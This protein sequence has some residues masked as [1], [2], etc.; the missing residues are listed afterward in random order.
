MSLIEFNH[1][2]PSV[3]VQSLTQAYGLSEMFYHNGTQNTKLERI[4]IM[5]Y[6]WYQRLSACHVTTVSVECWKAPQ[7]LKLCFTT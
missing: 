2:V 1:E 5:F 7:S 4:I 6:T 3:L